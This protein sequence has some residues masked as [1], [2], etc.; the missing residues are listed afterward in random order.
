MRRALMAGAR[1]FLIK[2][3]SRD[4]LMTSV[5]RVYHSPAA[6]HSHE[7]F[8]DLKQ[9]ILNKLVALLEPTINVLAPE[10]VQRAIQDKYER[11]LSQENIIL[12]R[13]ERVRLFESIVAEI[14]QTELGEPQKRA[15][16]QWFKFFKLGNKVEMSLAVADL[17]ESLSFYHKLGLEKVDDGEN[18]YPWAVVSDG[19]FYLGL[20]Q[21]KFPS[22]TLS[23]FGLGIL[24]ERMV[25]L[26]KLGIKLDNIQKLEPIQGMQNSELLYRVKFITA[27]FES[28]EGQ[29]VLLADLSSN[30]ETTPSGRKFY[31]KYD[32]ST[33]LS[34]PTPDINAALAYWGQLG[35]ECVTTG[36]QPY[37]WAT[38][39][40]GLIRLG[41]HQT[42]KLTQPTLTYFAPDMPERLKRMRRRGVTFVAERKDKQGR[43]VGAVVESPDGQRFFFF[44]GAIQPLK[45]Q[46]F[47]ANGT[48]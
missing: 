39:S 1:E 38:V 30:V 6:S 36:D 29:R 2:P 21:Q 32:G 43:R 24:S 27:E 3:F 44:T 28:P 48:I 42:P 35:F 37:P 8:N 45:P 4:E 13:S 18:P 17:S 10:E 5:R 16:A 33:E 15:L 26:P 11:I 25:H 46:K 9:H 20:H 23:Y 34:L 41:L 14:L 31:T 47:E 7:A 22:P 19:R 40:D 12:S